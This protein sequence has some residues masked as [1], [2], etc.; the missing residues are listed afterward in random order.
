[1]KV[2]LAVIFLLAAVGA[3]GMGVVSAPPSTMRARTVPTLVM[4]SVPG[5][6]K[7]MLL[8]KTETPAK[9]KQDDELEELKPPA[10]KPP[11]PKVEQP[12]AAEVQAAEAK[13]AEP[14]AAEPR[15]AAEPKVA[16]PRPTS[17]AAAAARP[18]ADP[19]P[20]ADPKAKPGDAKP[21]GLAKTA[22]PKADKAATGGA[23]GVTDGSLSL[24][25][26][27]TAD[28]YIDGRK[29]GGS[30]VLGHRV[31][32]GKH[33]IRFDCYDASGEAHQGTVQTVEVAVDG[34]RDVEYECPSQ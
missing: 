6:G 34:E 30:P 27:D 14:R 24:R 10:G 2:A 7:P 1:M 15:P 8:A 20:V 28:V 31:K 26:S 33:K 16:E 22:A 17:P 21:A 23:S 18:P 5:P 12:K 9:V 32:A 13:A 19:K 29:V 4:R 11:E 3:M 25:A